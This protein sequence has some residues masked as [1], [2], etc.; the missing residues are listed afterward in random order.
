MDL[1]RTRHAKRLGRRRQGG[2]GGEHV[3]HEEHP[4]PSDSLPR[5]EGAAHVRDAIQGAQADLRAS[6]AGSKEEPGLDTARKASKQL[7]HLVEA[8]LHEPV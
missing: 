7:P 8:A 2:A 1:T 6:P 5:L 3:I 4:P